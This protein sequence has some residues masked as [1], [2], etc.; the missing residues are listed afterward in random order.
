[1]ASHWMNLPVDI[2]AVILES[3]DMETVSNLCRAHSRLNNAIVDIRRTQAALRLAAPSGLPCVLSDP[4]PTSAAPI[5]QEDCECGDHRHAQHL[6][7]VHEMALSISNRPPCS[8]LQRAPT[9][10]VDVPRAQPWGRP[11]GWAWQELWPDV[12]I[13]EDICTVAVH[14]PKLRELRIAFRGDIGWP[15]DLEEEEGRNMAHLRSLC[16]E[17]GISVITV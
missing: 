13:W 1:M 16:S 4:D 11:A 3:A 7:R 14:L 2:F 9:F 5:N 8:L 17:R 12:Y 15:N 10:Y 6:R